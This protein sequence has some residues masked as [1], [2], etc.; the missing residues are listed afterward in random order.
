M[1]VKRM[2]LAN[3]TATLGSYVLW[4]DMRF[5]YKSADVAML[6]ICTLFGES[7]TW[8]DAGASMKENVR[9]TWLEL[10]EQTA[11]QVLRPQ[12]S[13]DHG[14]FVKRN[15][16]MIGSHNRP[17]ETGLANTDIIHLLGES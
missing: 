10:D 8:F 1:G 6:H 17:G 16:R 9:Q 11:R 15:D 7:H 4:E 12:K 13:R 5:P 14:K 2:A 3:K